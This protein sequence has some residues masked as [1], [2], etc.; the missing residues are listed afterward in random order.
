MGS[1]PRT[2]LGAAGA[3]A[4]SALVAAAQIG[5]ATDELKRAPAAPDQAWTVPPDSEYVKPLREASKTQAAPA[6]TVVPPQPPQEPEQEQSLDVSPQNRVQLEAGRSYTLAELIDIAERHNPETREAWEKARQAALSVGLAESK[7]LP[8][9]ALKVIGGYQRTPLPVPTSLLPAGFVTFVTGEFIPTLAA[10]WLLFDFG[11]QEAKAHE[12]EAKSFTA[13]ATFTEA[14]EKLIFAVSRDYFALG[15]ARARVRVAEYAAAN[16]LKTQEISEARRAH[17]VATVVEV[18]QA[19]RETA[20]ARFALVKAQGAARTAYSTLV[21]SMGVDPN[22]P[23]AVADS[24]DRPLPAAPLENVRALIENALVGRPDVLAA[25]GKVRAAQANL[26]NARAAYWPTL[27]L[28]A[29]LYGNIGWWSTG[30]P[31]FRLTRPGLN[32]MLALDLPIFEGGAREANVATARS[33]ISSARAALD[34][35]RDH[36]VEEVTR[37]YDQLQ[38][39]FA[40]YRAAGEVEAAARTAFDA[41]VDAYRS[42]VGPLT[43]AITAAN[44][45]SE[46]QLQREDARASVLTSAAELAFALGSATRR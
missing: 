21:A 7:L 16:A 38:T 24:S 18:A 40:E 28:D 15:A 20:Q 3:A 17:G 25:L 36:A 26:D 19:R 34:G 4:L 1:R 39:S 6:P 14:H 22:G 33:E 9:L 8:E 42:G 23:I 32:V 12:A 11:Q 35:V 10:K 30:G 27:Q 44:A 5:C 46:S 43:D 37:A 13:N 2:L 31:F 41:A 45:A 29:Q